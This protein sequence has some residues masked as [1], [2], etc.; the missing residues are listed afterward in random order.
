MFPIFRCRSKTLQLALAPILALMQSVDA[1]L[2]AIGAANGDCN[3]DM[4]LEDDADDRDADADANADINNRTFKPIYHWACVAH[5]AGPHGMMPMGAFLSP[6]RPQLPSA[7]PP[8]A[9]FCC[10]DQVS[11]S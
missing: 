5:N 11:D 4:D 10:C 6:L 1:R 8:T 3:D 7:P 9:A 2:P